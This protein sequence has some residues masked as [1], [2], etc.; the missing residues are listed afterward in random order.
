MN[1]YSL[2]WLVV[3]LL[4]LSNSG[5]WGAATGNAENS[6]LTMTMPNNEPLISEY[7]RA[8]YRE[9]GKRTGLAFNL[10]A[11]PKK[12]ALVTA[13]AGLDGGVASRVIGLEAAGYPNLIRVKVPVLRVQHVIFAKSNNFAGKI[14]NLDSL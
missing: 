11:L 2:C 13:N 6:A 5:S 9:I 1:K 10:I 8:I 7:M 4:A 14:D 3:S 12:R